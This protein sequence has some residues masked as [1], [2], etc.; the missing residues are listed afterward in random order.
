MMR[1]KLIIDLE[2]RFGERLENDKLILCL[3]E[4]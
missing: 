2:R 4:V 1:E 3:G